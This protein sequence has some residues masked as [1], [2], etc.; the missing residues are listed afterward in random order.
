MLEFLLK[1]T[2]ISFELI[3]EDTIKNVKVFF[4]EIKNSFYKIFL[5]KVYLKKVYE[6]TKNIQIIYQI[7]T[8]ILDRTIKL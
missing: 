8:G 5:F 6:N 3:E 7:D 4:N 2:L 1:R